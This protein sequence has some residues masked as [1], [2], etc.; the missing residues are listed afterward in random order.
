MKHVF[1]SV[2]LLSIASYT[3]G[4][5][6]VRT[7]K[8]TVAAN[9]I[10]DNGILSKK[11]LLEN[12]ATPIV[13]L[14]NIKTKIIDGLPINVKASNSF[15]PDIIVGTERKKPIAYIDI[16]VYRKQ[17]TALEM[18]VGYDLEITEQENSSGN[19]AQRPTTV[20]HSVLAN[21]NWYKIS[22][23]RRGIYKIDYN[24]LQSIGV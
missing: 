9:D 6:K 16:P 17:G 22:V 2:C 10:M 21:G 4:Q 23:P 1:L 24:F 7:T 15:D 19:T 11:I 18:L 5:T 14:L 12:T 8:H 3:F 13:R 20:A